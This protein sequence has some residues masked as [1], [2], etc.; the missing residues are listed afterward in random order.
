MNTKAVLE[1]ISQGKL[2]NNFIEIYVDAEQL[3]Y[4]RERY[5]NAIKKFEEYYGN[6]EIKIFSAPGSSEIGG[7]QVV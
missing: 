2:D 3:E 6:G 7:I 4:Q 5:I 1:L